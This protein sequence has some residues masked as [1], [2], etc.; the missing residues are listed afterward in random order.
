MRQGEHSS[1]G[2][3]A[4]EKEGGRRY[5][6]M[7][8]AAGHRAVLGESIGKDQG[9]N[10]GRLQMSYSPGNGESQKAS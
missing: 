7:T 1:L 5:S 3:E 9:K 4:G 8:E 2:L 10:K 6:H